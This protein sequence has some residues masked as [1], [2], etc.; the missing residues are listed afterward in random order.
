MVFTLV[1]RFLGNLE[2][3][4]SVLIF[5]YNPKNPITILLDTMI[6]TSVDLNAS[7]I[8]SQI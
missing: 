7:I 2:V 8:L 3:Q 5:K 1:T 6:L 4:C